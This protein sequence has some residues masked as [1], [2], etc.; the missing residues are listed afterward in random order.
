MRSESC[1]ALKQSNRTKG[2]S[3]SMETETEI[4]W[5]VPTSKIAELYNPMENDVWGCGEITPEDIDLACIEYLSVGR[6]PAGLTT[7]D[8]KTLEYNAARI[9]WIAE[10]YD[11]DADDSE[12]IT[13]EISGYG[14]IPPPIMDGNHRVA[15]AIYS[16]VEFLKVEVCGDLEQLK[17]ELQPISFSRV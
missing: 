1:S 15:A 8:S 3:C 11:W 2:S 7:E 9:A 5:I 17:E 16:G 6:L 4:I 10:N 13:I 14:L 12:P